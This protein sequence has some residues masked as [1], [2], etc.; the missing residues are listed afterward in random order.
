[1]PDEPLQGRGPTVFSTVLRGLLLISPLVIV[2]GYAA[3]AFV[4]LALGAVPTDLAAYAAERLV[5][6]ALLLLGASGAV[7]LALYW[8]HTQRVEP[9][10]HLLVQM[11][12]LCDA[13]G[14]DRVDVHGSGDLREVAKAINTLAARLEERHAAMRESQ[15]LAAVGTL[16]A[17]VAHEIN[18]PLTYMKGSTDLVLHDLE[19]FGTLEA[20]PEETRVR[21][22]ESAETLRVTLEG[23]D[24]LATIAAT[25][26]RVSRPSQGARTPEDVNGLVQSCLLLARNDL[27]GKNTVHLELHAE[28]PV[29]CNG[30]EISQVLLNLV[31][32]GLQ[33]MPEGGRLTVRTLDHGDC[34]AI[35]V[36][37]TGPGIPPEVRDHLFTPFFTTKPKGT[38]LGLSIC[39]GLVEAHQGRLTFETAPGMGTTFRVELPLAAASVA[40]P[41]LSPV[42]EAI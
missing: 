20:I 9:L 27:K 11:E 36:A 35:E 8:M 25:L 34:V 24:R 42:A 10:R 40:P 22:V 14:A 19:E 13:T 37:D 33:A 17:G 23:M 21:I 26:K 15:R 39:K 7:A 6:L 41:P 30:A 29:L 4:P 28:R 38:G 1:M 16:V 12:D 32:N 3:Y 31:L 5:T 18:N 2:L